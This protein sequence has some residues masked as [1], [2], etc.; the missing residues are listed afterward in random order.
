MMGGR[1]RMLRPAALT[2]RPSVSVVV[3]V[4]NYG[5][6]L[7]ECVESALTQA[8]VDVEVLIIDDA[9]TDDSLT[10]AHLIA[11]RDD[12]VRVISN[13]R[14]LGMVGTIN[15][16]L[17]EVTGRYLVKLDAD[18]MLT[19]GSLARAT[20][21]MEVHPSIGFVYGFPV[22]F[23]N[24]PPF[25]VRTKVRSWTVWSGQEWIRTRC[26]VG[27]NCILQPEAVIRA[28]VIR[29]AGPYRAELGH[30]PDFDMWL[31]MASLGKVGRVNGV[32]QGY[33]RIHANS[34]QRS[35]NDF[36]L[37]DLMRRR[38]I[39]ALLFG[40]PGRTFSDRDLMWKS[41]CRAMAREA[42]DH[43]CRAYENGRAAEQSLDGYVAFALDVYQGT[44]KLCQWRQLERYRNG[45]M[46]RA[47]TVPIALTSRVLHNVQDRVQWRRWR[48][49][50]V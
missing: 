28:T 10:A 42:L 30:A 6:F 17:S 22:E 43:V 20:A 36:P 40:G 2:T 18:D 19:P 35:M 15:A 38:E 39:F 26:R 23:S 47:A 37:Q 29:E 14:N 27:R 12:R 4:H 44:P 45:G 5:R 48:W 21:L 1:A 32:D 8:G 11:E 25:S 34:M 7:P 16:G 49:S 50:G 13:E 24:D 41:A 31:R 3:P 33:Y 46:D 9:S